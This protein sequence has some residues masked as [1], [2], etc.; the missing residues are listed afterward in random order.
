MSII[1]EQPSGELVI[2]TI[3]M[4]A[5]TNTYGDMFGGWV[6]SQM[7]L[8][9]AVLA[10][11]CAKK[12]MTTVAI[13]SMVFMKPIFVGDLVSCYAEVFKKG[14]TSVTIHVDVWV[15]RQKDASFHHVTKGLFTFVAIDD[16]GRP[17][18]IDWSASQ[19]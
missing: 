15:Q 2:R 13:D 8:G 4:P 12:H 1:P 5:D 16:E 3:A 7:D 9:G 10:H 18:P 17:T 6:V 19:I 14:R 11:K